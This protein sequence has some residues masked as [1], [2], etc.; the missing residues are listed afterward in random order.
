MAAPDFLL[1]GIKSQGTLRQKQT[2]A[3]RQHQKH[4][5]PGHTAPE[6]D[7]GLEELLEAF[8]VSGQG[9]RAFHAR[10]EML[11]AAPGDC[12]CSEL[13]QALNDVGVGPF[14]IE[15][16]LNR[17]DIATITCNDERSDVGEQSALNHLIGITLRAAEVVL[18]RRLSVAR[19]PSDH[20]KKLIRLHICAKK[21]ALKAHE[22]RTLCFVERMDV[23]AAESTTFRKA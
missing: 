17:A 1:P 22:D 10:K 16:S 8:V 2:E 21:N 19:K 15:S 5:K 3:T 14:H 4:R 11:L 23:R 12:G 6:A 18:L 7:E 9:A 13:A 20:R